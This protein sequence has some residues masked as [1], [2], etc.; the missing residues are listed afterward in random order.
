MIDFER[1]LYVSIC[2]LPNGPRP[3]PLNSGFSENVAYRVIGMYN[4]SESGE[5]WFVLANDAD[6]M[7][8]ISQR[9][10]RVQSIRIDIVD[11]R[12]SLARHVEPVSADRQR[13]VA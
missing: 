3:L 2:E 10:L 4:P 7:W 13:R 8:F 9:H 1:G 11:F 12:Y 5:C 6:Q